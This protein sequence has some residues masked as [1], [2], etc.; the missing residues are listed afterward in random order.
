MLWHNFGYFR[1][2]FKSFEG[3][4]DRN[5]S[6]ILAKSFPDKRNLFVRV[7]TFERII[8][9]AGFIDAQE[10]VLDTAV[11][12]KDLFVRA[13]AYA[14]LSS[15]GFK[16]GAKSDGKLSLLVEVLHDIHL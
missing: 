15:N 2:P 6:V 16:T 14:L 5:L 3:T 1:S 7:L 4:E 10:L 11:S 13:S 12:E 8:S 9:F